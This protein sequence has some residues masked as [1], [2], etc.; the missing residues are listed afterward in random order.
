MQPAHC[1]VHP[2]SLGRSIVNLFIA[3]GA[4]QWLTMSRIVRGQVLSLKRREFVEAA[5][6][7]GVPAR[8]IVWRHLVRNTVGPVIVSAQ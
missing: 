4:V 7:L 8:R 1:P 3:L 2:F 6:A 5:V